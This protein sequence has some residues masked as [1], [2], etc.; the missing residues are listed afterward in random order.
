MNKSLNIKLTKASAGSGKTFSLMNKIADLVNSGMDPA[1]LLVTTFTV[2]AANELKER[3][4]G[5]LIDMGR[6]DLAQKVSA[7]LI[8]TVNGVCGRLLAE[9]AIESGLSP[10]LDVLADENASTIFKKSVASVLE[11]RMHEIEP[12]AFRFGMLEEQCSGKF[13]RGESWWQSI[14]D[15]TDRARANGFINPKTGMVDAEKVKRSLALSLELVDGLFSGCVDFPLDSGVNDVIAQELG[16]IRNI[17]KADTNENGEANPATLSFCRRVVDFLREPTWKNALPPSTAPGNKK[18]SSQ[19]YASRLKPLHMALKT[20][21]VNSRRLKDDAK[22]IVRVMFDIMT[23]AINAY[24]KFKKRYGLIDFVDQETMLLE[25]LENNAHF[26][27]S[28]K[29]RVKVVMVDEFQDTSPLQLAVFLKMNELVGSSIWVGDPKQ[30]IYGFRGTDPELINNVAREIEASNPD[31]M[32]ILKFSWRSRE[33][34][35]NF[36]N[37]VFAKTFEN[38]MTEKEVVL[39]IDWEH[40]DDAKKPGRQGGELESWVVDSKSESYAALLADGVRMYLDEHPGLHYRDIAILTRGNDMSEQIA[41]GLSALGIPAS[42][43]SGL[44]NVQPI[45]QLAMSAYRYAIDSKDTIALATLVAYTMDDREWFSHLV[46]GRCVENPEG[47]Y[48]RAGNMTLE[49]WAE[50]IHIK[51]LTDGIGKKG[52]LTPIEML[53]C[54][55]G[56]FAL[57]E[58]AGRMKD[59]Q[60]A[61]MNLEALRELCRDFIQGA[62]LGGYPITHAGFV[63]YYDKSEAPEASLEGG[64]CVQ[65]MTYHKSKGLEWSVVILTELQKKPMT[66]VFDLSVV[67]AGDFNPDT[68]LADRLLRRVFNP[69]EADSPFSGSEK[70]KEI[71]SSL[72]SSAKE[73]MKRLMY[74]GMTRARDVLILAPQLNNRKKDDEVDAKWL[75]G[76]SEHSMFA[77]NWVLEDKL[78]TAWNIDGKEFSVRSRFLTVHEGAGEEDNEMSEEREEDF[79]WCD[80]EEGSQKAHLEANLTPSG[81]DGGRVPV[82]IM[83]VAKIGNY[84]SVNKEDEESAALGNAMHSYYAVAVNSNDDKALAEAILEHWNVKELLSPELLVASGA[85]LRKYIKD[86]WPDGEILTEVP[87]TLVNDD[88]QCYQGFIDML[89]KNGS[90]YI[91]IDHKTGMSRDYEKVAQKYTGQLCIYKRAIESALHGNVASIVLHLP[92]CGT[93]VECKL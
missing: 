36:A 22:E 88:G 12:L 44:L 21:V 57:D 84:F 19:D 32:E 3:I 64:D 76:L 38:S 60:R 27:E 75:D 11:A 78:D 4:R 31:N 26:R 41:L 89:V 85:N 9:Y 35:V 16:L 48:A 77:E 81:E 67:Q 53:D 14:L 90:D 72:E 1:S 56:I 62:E 8:G 45:C 34:L 39:G 18:G 52:T 69:F 42:A 23:A 37:A 28:F 74:V 70:Y 5:K 54:I 58:Y 51:R 73:E 15:M 40:I 46:E 91:L 49:Q 65:V 6:I 71:S 83:R 63:N 29:E 87:M 30:A 61:L 25:L 50:D 2:K 7:G 20:N 68:P 10:Q 79:A 13:S 55:I 80:D 59:P 93:C 33:N 24:Q 66:N 82:E 86:N 17:N 43:S 92:V 47:E